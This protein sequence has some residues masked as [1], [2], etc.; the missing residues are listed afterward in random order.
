MYRPLGYA[1]SNT[2]HQCSQSRVTKKRRCYTNS[3]IKIFLY[4]FH[5]SSR[6]RISSPKCF[7]HLFCVQKSILKTTLQKNRIS[8]K[9]TDLIRYLAMSVR[10]LQFDIGTT[11]A[12]FIEL[13]SW[14][15]WMDL[16][17]VLSFIAAEITATNFN[18][19][20]VE[21]RVS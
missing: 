3:F 15:V 10:E 16:F 12:K 17:T 11:L 20:F 2:S 14:L 18:V 19:F 8:N 1:K 13:G 7:D 4:L 5:D 6:T 21:C 9:S